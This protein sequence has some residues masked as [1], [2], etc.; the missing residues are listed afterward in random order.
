MKRSLSVVLAIIATACGAP[1]ARA[2]LDSLLGDWAEAASHDSDNYDSG[3]YTTEGFT[4]APA[5]AG[6]AEEDISGKPS[7]DKTLTSNHADVVHDLDSEVAVADTYEAITPTINPYYTPSSED[8]GC[9][10]GQAKKKFS[11]GCGG[12]GEMIPCNQSC[13]CKGLSECRPHQ[14]PALPPP[15]SLLQ[16]FRSKNSYSTIWS[17]YAEE[18]RSRCRNTSPHVLGTW[19]T[20]D[21]GG[22]LEPGCNTCE[23]ATPCD[24]CESGCDQ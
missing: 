22:L 15:S 17:G 13:H 5:S 16:M 2:D 7:K 23:A 21:E 10:S 8:C 24:T 12:G 18:T 11:C 20:C 19:R 4:L 6:L 9:D 14:R 1:A 3:N